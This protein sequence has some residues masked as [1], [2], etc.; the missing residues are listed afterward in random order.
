MESEYQGPGDDNLPA[1]IW[2]GRNMGSG[3]HPS[4]RKYDGLRSPIPV[5]ESKISAM[6]IDSMGTECRY[7]ARYQMGRYRR[8]LWRRP[9]PYRFTDSSYGKR[10]TRRQR[11]IPSV[12]RLP[13]YSLEYGE[14]GKVLSARVFIENFR[15]EDL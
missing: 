6:R 1:R 7:G 14:H 9:V 11:L 15:E 5:S 13:F 4:G 2:F 3:T 12:V 8:M 10:Y